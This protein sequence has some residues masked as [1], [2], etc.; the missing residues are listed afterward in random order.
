MNYIKI[1]KI[2]NRIKPNYYAE[3]KELLLLPIPTRV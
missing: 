3:Y 2:Y 1:Y